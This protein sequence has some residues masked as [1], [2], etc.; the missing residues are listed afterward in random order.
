M[1]YA[2]ELYHGYG[3]ANTDEG[4]L[5]FWHAALISAHRAHRGF[6]RKAKPEKQH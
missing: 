1:L 5:M 2:I 3:Q 4:A 6:L